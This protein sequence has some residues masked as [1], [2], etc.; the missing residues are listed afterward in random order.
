VA[1]GSEDFGVFEF[2]KSKC[3]NL[4]V[5]L[6]QATKAQKGSRGI[7]TLS[8][9]SAVVGASSG[10][11]T[12]RNDSIPI[13]YEAILRSAVYRVVFSYSHGLALRRRFL[14]YLSGLC[15]FQTAA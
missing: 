3:K 9:T 14:G 13:I 5:N 4:K 10:R 8:L 7:T 2:C 6:E 11:F 1:A 12:A 15:L